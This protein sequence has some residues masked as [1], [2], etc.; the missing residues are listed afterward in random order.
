MQLFRARRD[1]DRDRRHHES[2]VPDALGHADLPDHGP[3]DRRDERLQQ[4]D[5]AELPRPERLPTHPTGP[6]TKITNLYQ[7]TDTSVSPVGSYGDDYIAGGAARTTRSSA[8][9]ATTRSRATARSTTQPRA[10]RRRLDVEHRERLLLAT[11]P[12]IDGAGDGNDY[13]EGGGGNDVIFGNH[14]QDDIIGGS[15]N[16]FSLDARRATAARR[17]RHDLRRLGHRHRARRRAAT[18]ANGH[19]HDGDTILGDNGDIFRLVGG[20]TGQFL[21]F[22]YDN[23]ARRQD[24]P[25]G[26]PA[27]RLH[28]R[29]A[30]FDPATPHRHRRDDLIHGENG[31]DF[32]YGKVGN[33]AIFGDGQDDTIVGGYGAGLDLRRQRRRRHPRRRRPD[34]LSRVGTAEPLAGVPVVA[35]QSTQLTLDGAQQ[36]VLTNSTNTLLGGSS[37]AGQPRSLDVQHAEPERDLRAARR[38]R[39][40]LRRPR[41]RL[42][43]RRRGRRRDLGRRGACGCVHQQLRGRQGRRPR[44]S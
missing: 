33:D 6:S 8:S 13:I 20:A 28:A 24:R 43:P 44:R 36:D 19:S 22:N 7:S 3:S 21:S 41:Q 5:R 38:Q 9:R 1:P 17:R 16:L 26:D 40:D 39:H 32:I 23:Y 15:S 27:P 34:L 42:H 18:R 4:R 29:R 35:G 10:A 2:A 25:A 31:D 37:G 14:G 30:R 12:S 11:C